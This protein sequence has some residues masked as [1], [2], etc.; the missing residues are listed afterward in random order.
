LAAFKTYDWPGN[1]RELK[2]TIRRAVLLT[3][4]ATIGTDALPQEMIDAINK[5]KP[6]P[7]ENEPPGYDL[8][9]LQEKHE[10][11][12]IIKTLRDVR[13]NKAKAARLLNIDRKT[14]YLKM[15][16]YNIL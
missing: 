13:F 16:K 12:L 7:A 15:E 5:P 9:V 6:V 14:L 8:K 4:G 1:L 10:R 3:P 11:E 2:N